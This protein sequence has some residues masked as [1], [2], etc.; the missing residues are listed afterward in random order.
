MT[1]HPIRGMNM[2]SD[3]TASNGATTHLGEIFAG[4]GS[5]Y[6]DG[7]VAVDRA[8]IPVSLAANP[9]ATITALTER[10]VEGVAEKKG[11][12]IDY[13]TRNGIS[14]NLT[15]PFQAKH[16]VQAFWIPEATHSIQSFTI[17]HPKL[18]ILCTI[19]PI[20]KVEVSYSLK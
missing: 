8:A 3:G 1:V 4:N 11:I 12:S 15:C 2:S 5:S 20:L 10:S 18:K 17:N 14:D 19:L 7:L 9:F 6:H 13:E 16:F